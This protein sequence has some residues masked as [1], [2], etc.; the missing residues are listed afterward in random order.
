MHKYNQPSLLNSQLYYYNIMNI[1]NVGSPFNI[2]I[3]YI[4]YGYLKVRKTKV[5]K[6]TSHHKKNV[7]DDYSNDND[8]NMFKHIP[9]IMRKIK[10][11]Q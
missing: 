4:I 10:I 5:L 11:N 7:H 9:T 1:D 6:C 3:E 8:D 2:A